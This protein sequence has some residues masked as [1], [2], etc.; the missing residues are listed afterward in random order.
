MNPTKIDFIDITHIPVEAWTVED[1]RDL[2]DGIMQI[3]QKIGH[4][5]TKNVPAW[6]CARC[7][8]VGFYVGTFKPYLFSRQADDFKAKHQ[9][10][11]LSIDGGGI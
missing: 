6:T 10:C 1:W 3:R 7:G 9:A 2:Q 5:H 11:P 8:A 4:R